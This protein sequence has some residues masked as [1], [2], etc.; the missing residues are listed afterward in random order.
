MPVSAKVDEVPCFRSRGRWKQ[1]LHS[2]SIITNVYKGAEIVIFA[3][4]PDPLEMSCSHVPSR[5]AIVTTRTPN[6]LQN[7]VGSSSGL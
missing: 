7:D 6:T 1:A 5:A 4:G 2:D 3:G